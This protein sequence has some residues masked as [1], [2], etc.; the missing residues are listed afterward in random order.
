MDNAAPADWIE[1]VRRAA[2][3]VG[4]IWIALWVTR[5]VAW[6]TGLGGIALAFVALAL[7][8]L[9]ACCGWARAQELT[10][11]ESQERRD[12]ILGWSIVGALIGAIAIGAL[13]SVWV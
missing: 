11:L 1:R 8:L 9:G 6:V 2:L 13:I 12:A 7:A 5:F 4:G 3:V 10:P